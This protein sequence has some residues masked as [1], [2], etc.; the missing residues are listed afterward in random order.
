MKYI[1]QYEVLNSNNK[2][3]LFHFKP[4]TIPNNDFRQK[5]FTL[6]MKIGK[7]HGNKFSETSQEK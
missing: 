7:F 2:A 3:Q 1:N 5:G 4:K 6:D